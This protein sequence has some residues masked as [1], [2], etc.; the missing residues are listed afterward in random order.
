MKLSLNQCKDKLKN[1]G[2]R[3]TPQRLAIYHF[4]TDTAIHPSA[5]TVYRN[6][7]HNYP[8]ISFDTVNR[9]LVSFNKKGIIKLVE[10][11]F[12]PRRY[13]ASLKL[14][15]HFRCIA[16]HKIIDFECPYYDKIDIPAEISKKFHVLHQEIVLK[17]L[18]SE[19]IKKKLSAQQRNM[20]KSR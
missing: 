9:T 8:C 14:H 19:C 1:A 2:I 13:D 5:E 10:S 12:G 20:T 4:L 3:V 6:I 7:K 15:Y 11:G 18:C 16:C 17:G